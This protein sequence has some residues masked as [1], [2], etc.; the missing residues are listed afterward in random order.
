MTC[1]VVVG[2]FVRAY[3]PFDTEPEAKAW[4]EMANFTSL[5][6]NGRM[7]TTIVRLTEPAKLWAFKVRV[8]I[9]EEDPEVWF[10]EWFPVGA[11]NFEDAEA[12]AIGVAMAKYPGRHQYAAFDTT[13][14]N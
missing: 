8:E 7:S 10:E 5:T 13:I 1:I 6:D 12:R 2:N 9:S 11:K 14:R 3:G 4:E